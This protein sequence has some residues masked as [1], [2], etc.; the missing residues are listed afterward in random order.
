MANR[1][2][3]IAYIKI[4]PDRGSGKRFEIQRSRERIARK[5]YAELNEYSAGSNPVDFTLTAPGGGATDAIVVSADS[6]SDS[7]YAAAVKPQMGEFPD[8][9]TVS[10]FCT[11]TDAQYTALPEASPHGTK[12]VINASQSYT[13]TGQQ[14]AISGPASNIQDGAPTAQNQYG[15]ALLK[16]SIESAIGLLGSVIRLEF[17]GVKYGQ[18]GLTFA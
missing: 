15:A 3:F 17:N 1:L 16:N 8:V 13:T 11:L 5:I 14:S 6:L 4:T 9:V 10:G 18:G 2:P 7:A 12:K